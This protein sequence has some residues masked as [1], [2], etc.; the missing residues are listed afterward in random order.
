MAQQPITL[1]IINRTPAILLDVEV[2]NAIKTVIGKHQPSLD[3]TISSG[4]PGVDLEE[5]VADILFL[6]KPLE[7]FL[8]RMISNLPDVMDKKLRVTSRDIKG[9]AAMVCLKMEKQNYDLPFTAASKFQAQKSVADVKGKFL[10]NRMTSLI[11]DKL[12]PGEE[13]ALLLFF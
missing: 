11:L 12:L 8:A 7:V 5:I 6:Q 2:F 4:V 10:I 9:N 13:I 1:N 3:Y